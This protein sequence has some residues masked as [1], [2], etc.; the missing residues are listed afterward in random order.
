MQ[1]LFI[2]LLLLSSLYAKNTDFS[3][4]IDEPFNDALLDITQDYDRQISAIGFSKKYK[5]ESHHKNNT[6]TDAFDYL[7]SIADAHGSQMQLIKVNRYADITLNKTTK[8]S[9]FSKA[10][11][12]V[13]TPANGYYIGGYTLDGSLLIL[14]V[15][16][17]ANLIF[18]K[19]FGTKNY[20][21]M[22]N[23]IKLSDGGV[24]AI[25]SSISSRSQHDSLFETGLG[26]NDIYLTR[27]SKDGRK[28]WSKKYGTIYDDRGIDAVEAFDGSILVI[29]TTRY[30]NN[31]HL[32]LMRINENGDK[33]WLKHYKTKEVI[34][35]YK[36][37]RLRDDNFLISL[38][39]KDEM[40]KE[41]IRLIKFD[42]QKN[43]LFDKIIHTTYSS[44]LLDIKEYS[45]SSLIGVGYVRDAYNTDA[46][47]MLLDNALNL[48]HQEHYGEENYDIL[49]AVTTLHNSQAA[50]AG[51]RTQE[52]SE[53]SNMWIVK[54][55]RDATIAKKATPSV[56]IYEELQRLFKDDIASH[57]L[58]IDKE[59]NIEFT[60]TKLYFDVAKYNLSDV[61]KRYL[62]KFCKILIPFLHEHQ[63]QIHSIEI[64]GHT[65]SEWN[66][67]DFSSRY[68]NNVK[69]SMNR[70]FATLKFIF[71][72]QDLN[73][74]KWLTKKFKGSGLSYSKKVTFNENE[75]REKSRRVSF[76]IILK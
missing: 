70:S 55:N 54:L 41:K 57:K 63:K 12:L 35:P 61:Q 1:K 20:D 60:D 40:N 3:V 50:A 66:G 34:T 4:I 28:L 75:D 5:Q 33:I 27:F 6:Y 46:L 71:Q 30:E 36:I 49:N 10:I 64:D 42:I 8:M 65:S 67:V 48:L 29:S 43:V 44:G 24:L 31:K 26:L 76:R 52:G 62:S 38:N 68:L 18:K 9:K 17:D 45:N 59:L 56:D 51:I 21:R 25:G 14:K 73:T 53:E 39:Q 16:S 47:V 11:A 2:L 13:K 37:I 22:N 58:K 23:L 15:D 19:T 32:T 7:S 74:Q 69:L 72:N